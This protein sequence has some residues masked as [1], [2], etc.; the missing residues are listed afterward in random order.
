MW[1]WK[2]GVLLWG[3]RQRRGVRK[4]RCQGGRSQGLGKVHRTPIRQE[5]AC[6]SSHRNGPAYVCEIVELGFEKEKPKNAI[7]GAFSV[8]IF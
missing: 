1:R 3:I 5:R 2:V 6:F 7:F 8:I 4:I